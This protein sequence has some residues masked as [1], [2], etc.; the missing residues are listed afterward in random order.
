[1]A[2]LTNLLATLGGTLQGGAT[3][4]SF[5]WNRF[6]ALIGV[7]RGLA[8]GDNLIAGRGIRLDKQLGKVIVT[9]D[10]TAG[11]ATAAAH[12]FQLTDAS[13]GATLKVKIKFGMVN[14]IT[15][16]G[17][18]DTEEPDLTLTIN[19]TKYVAL[20]VTTNGGGA[21]T[22][23]AITLQTEVP[24]STATLAYIPLG[25]VTYTAAVGDTPAS[26]AMNQSV[27]GSLWHQRCGSA[28]HLFGSV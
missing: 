20:S 5:G 16:G 11:K 1:M 4:T 3:F 14:A 27:S 19:A 17:M 28:T 10:A 22:S 13:V 12:P 6:N 2:N 9:S 18:G 23:A 8:A 21:A 26:I 25:L 15:P 7:V 24:E